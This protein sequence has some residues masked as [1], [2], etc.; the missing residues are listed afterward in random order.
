MTPE[1]GRQNTGGESDGEGEQKLKRGVGVK[2]DDSFQ[3][4]RQNTKQKRGS[5]PRFE[6]T[7]GVSG[8]LYVTEKIC[9]LSIIQ[10]ADN[11]E[12]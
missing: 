11:N 10:F 7:M 8:W 5:G 3:S 1:A 12:D 9:N 6:E 2:H 4:E